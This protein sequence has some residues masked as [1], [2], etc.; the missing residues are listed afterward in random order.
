MTTTT[1][2]TISASAPAV[3]WEPCRAFHDEADGDPSGVCGGCGWPPDDHELL[4]A[5]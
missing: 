2:T 4:A 3:R 5:A 1:L